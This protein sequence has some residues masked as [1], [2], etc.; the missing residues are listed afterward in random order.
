MGTSDS[1]VDMYVELNRTHFNTG[2][3]V[4]GTVHLNIKENCP[5]SG[6]YLELQGN[7]NVEWE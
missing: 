1:R 2:D 6:L 4:E 5:F 3:Y 7:E